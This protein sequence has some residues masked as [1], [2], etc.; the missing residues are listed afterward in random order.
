MFT[1]ERWCEFY[2]VLLICF[3]TK[4]SKLTAHNV[5]K[6]QHNSIYSVFQTLTHAFKS[7]S[8]R[9][10]HGPLYRII[11]FITLLL[12]NQGYVGYVGY[13][14]CYIMW[15]WSSV[16][17]ALWPYSDTELMRSRLKGIK[18]QGRDHNNL[19]DCTVTSYDVMVVECCCNVRL[20]VSSFVLVSTMT[21]LGRVL[22]KDALLPCY[23]ADENVAC[24]SILIYSASISMRLV[25]G[26]KFDWMT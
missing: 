6:F 3:M 21:S 19:K 10:L 5:S 12:H 16:H 13:H 11:H 26:L 22:I 2:Q 15:E 8:Q 14:M 20:R 7:P 25:F 17:C 24:R 23:N 9:S 1:C 4:L 18:I